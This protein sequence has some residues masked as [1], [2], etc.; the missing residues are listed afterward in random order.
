MIR[1]ILLSLLALTSTSQAVDATLMQNNIKHVV[2]LML[3][4]RSYDNVLAWLYNE[5]DAPQTF[6]P[7]S[8]EPVYKGL[9]EATLQFYTNHLKDSSGNIVFSSPPIKGVPSVAD[10]PYLNSPQYNPYETFPN[11]LQQLYSDVTNNEPDM[12]G[13]LQ[14][15]AS[16]W[17]DQSWESDQKTILGVMETYTEK[18]LPIIYG[19]AKHYAVSDEWF[20]SVPSDT[21]P[22]RAFAACGTSEGQIVDGP[23]TKS[24][25][26]S[27]TIWNKFTDLSPETTWKI[28][29]QSNMVTGLIYGPWTGPNSFDAMNRI[30]DLQSHYDSIAGFHELARN[31]QLPAFSFIEPQMTSVKE[32]VAGLPIE[33]LSGYRMMFGLQ[34]NDMHPPGDVRPTENL[35]ANIYT[36]LIANPEA[37][38][39]TLLVITFDEHG[40]LFD[41]VT[42]PK[43][44]APDSHFENGFMFDRYGVRVPTIFI[45]PLIQKSTVVRSDNPNIPFDHTSLLATLLQWKNIDKSLWNMGH[46]T[47]V[48]PSFDSVLTRSTLRTDVVVAPNTAKVYAKNAANIVN[49]GDTFY[50]RD[51]NG[52]YLVNN[53][54]FFAEGAFAG[55]SQD[56]VK[57]RFT[58]GTGAISHGSFAFIE[59]TDESLGSAN[60]LQS[61]LFDA[62]CL[63]A[64]RSFSSGQWWTVKSVNVP[65]LGAPILFGDK[66]YLENHIFLDIFQLVPAR[67]S[68]KGGFLS[69]NLL[70]CTSIADETSNDNYWIIEKAS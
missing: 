24:M 46:R 8:T 70:T 67:L 21:N 12:K 18:E 13:F 45:S 19:L 5:H 49:M 48:A 33:E 9:S 30:P 16:C 44:I 35:I 2:V 22:N 31:G 59:S 65:F 66:V 38:N 42:P 60:V 68:S 37:W 4:N 63:Y 61:S 52:N 1:P 27:D 25:F 17:W 29:W 34:G 51:K 10:W 40:G 26:Y 43:A 28:F 50:L 41:H 23:F 53:S 54:L 32:L 62:D 14:N 3:E 57:L 36:S 39:E 69:K 7:D 15:Y 58:G 20:C 56:K 64:E 55:S 6:I 47:A 11:I